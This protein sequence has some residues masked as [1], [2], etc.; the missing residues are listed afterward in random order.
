[1]KLIPC[2]TIDINCLKD[3]LLI[4]ENGEEFYCGGIGLGLDDM[5]IWIDLIDP[6]TDEFECALP[7]EQLKNWSVQLH[8]H[9]F[10]LCPQIDQP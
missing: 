8:S 7:I 9:S 5:Q 1:M 10:R 4:N 3:A 6:E 2:S